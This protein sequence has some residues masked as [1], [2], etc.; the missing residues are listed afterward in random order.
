MLENTFCHIQGIGPRTEQRLWESDICDWQSFLSL[1]G[2]RPSCGRMGSDMAAAAI[3]LSVQA[4]DAGQTSYFYKCLKPAEHWRMFKDFKHKTAYVDIE[5]TGLD[6]GFSSITTIALYDG[7][8]ILTYVNGQNLTCFADDILNYDL[9]VTFNGKSF[10]VPFIE[11]FF[12][13][14]LPH[15]HIDLRHVLR[16]LGFKGGLKKIEKEFGLSRNELDGVDG[17]FAVLLWH[18]YENNRNPRALETLLAYNVEDVVNLEFLMHHA[19]N[20]KLRNTPFESNLRM[21]VPLRPKV[22][23]AP[24]TDLVNHLRDRYY[25][26]HY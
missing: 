21:A 18:E 5:T 1:N 15:A 19:Y 9:L 14:K 22:M 12:R 4:L 3:S 6:A 26:C 7:E 17:F 8:K 25:P 13:I 20:L 16:S 2:N 24:D 10:D 23:Y 11:S